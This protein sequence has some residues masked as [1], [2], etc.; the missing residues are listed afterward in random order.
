MLEYTVKGIA[1]AVKVVGASRR[2]ER[3][4]PYDEA[5]ERLDSPPT[6]YTP[7]Q[8]NADLDLV[9]E[10]VYTPGDEQYS[11]RNQRRRAAGLGLGSAGEG[12]VRAVGGVSAAVSAVAPWL[13]PVCV[14][15]VVVVVGVVVVRR[16]LKMGR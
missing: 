12:I 1:K 14:G 8:Q 6:G 16:A 3:L 11:L 15:V 13:M 9:D 5:K 7:A 4:R 2:V 10:Y